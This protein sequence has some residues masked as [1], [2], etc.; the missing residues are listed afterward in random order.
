MVT[1]EHLKLSPLA[2][3]PPALIYAHANFGCTFKIFRGVTARIG[4]ARMGMGKNWQKSD[5]NEQIFLFCPFPF[6]PAHICPFW[7]FC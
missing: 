4:W 2:L 6:T 3:K 7:L 5:K 1:Y